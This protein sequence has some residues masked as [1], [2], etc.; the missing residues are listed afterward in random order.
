TGLISTGSRAAERYLF[1]LPA[2]GRPGVS[3]VRAIL[4]DAFPEATISDYRET[5]PII[6]RGLDRATTFLSLIALIALVIRPTGVASPLHCPLQQKRHSIAVMKCIG[7]RFAQVI[8]I[9]TAQTLMLG[10][11]GGLIGVTFG[12]AVAAAFPGF[13]AKYF[14]VDVA[15]Y[16]DAWPAL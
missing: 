14:Q 3:E 9:Y 10:L 2:A 7:A 8:R 16:W 5:H 15:A 11:A 4:K 12:V 6:T 13:I 1:A